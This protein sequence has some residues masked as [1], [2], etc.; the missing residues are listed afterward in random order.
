MVT[1]FRSK[2]D[3][4]L[5]VALL[6]IPCLA[7]VAIG[8]NLRRLPAAPLA[9]LAPC[10]IAGLVVALGLWLMASTRYEV[11]ADILTVRCGPFAWRVPL[12][13]IHRVVATRDPASGPA[14]SL[15]RLRI[16]Y[17]AGQVLLV[18]PDDRTAFLAAIGQRPRR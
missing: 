2:V 6:G 13:E 4:W 11:G 7:L 14:L 16:E 18:S 9:L 3:A 15:D 1:V 12:A 17:G 5:V 10:A 8:L